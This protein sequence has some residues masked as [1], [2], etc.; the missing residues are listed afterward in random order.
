MRKFFENLQYVTLVL[1]IVGQCTVGSLFYVGQVMYL[2]ANVISVT[3][4]F[5][6]NRPMADK[7]KDICCLAITIGLLFIKTFAIKS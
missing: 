2:V 1:L 3:R 4:C 5:A 6:L 7:I